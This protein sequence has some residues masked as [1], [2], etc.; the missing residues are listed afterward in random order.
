MRTGNGSQFIR[1]RVSR[2]K[3]PHEPNLDCVLLD[4]ETRRC[5]IYSVRPKQCRTFPFWDDV[6]ES[7]MNWQMYKENCPGIGNGR[8][9]T[10]EEIEEIMK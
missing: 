10:A 5:R 6:L 2:R 1:C 4:S 7:E 8:S 9:Y 3:A